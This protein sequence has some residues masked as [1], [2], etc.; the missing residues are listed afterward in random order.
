MLISGR[1]ELAAVLLVLIL[2]GLL[3]IV[4]SFETS[5]LFFDFVLIWTRIENSASETKVGY[6]YD[7]PEANT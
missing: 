1:T 6:R 2:D 5:S 3:V 7:G 4:Q